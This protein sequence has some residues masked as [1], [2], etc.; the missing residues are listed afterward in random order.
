M[1]ALNDI[2]TLDF[3]TNANTGA[4]VDAD[5][6]PTYEIFEDDNDTPILSGNATKRTSKTGNYRITF[7]ASAAN[8]FENGK[9]YN[10]IA[11]AT[12]ATIAGK[13]R[14]STFKV[15]TSTLSGPSS[16][17][18]TFEDSNSDPVPL[19]N[20]TILGIA[21]G[22]ADVDGEAAFGLLD[23][24]YTVVAAPTQGVFFPNTTLVVS[25][26][27]TQTITGTSPTVTPPANPDLSLVYG[28]LVD[29]SG[30]PLA[31]VKVKFTLVSTG[32]A[33]DGGLL[34]Q[35]NPPMEA[36]TDSAGHFEIEL[37]KTSALLPS[38][39]LYRIECAPAKFN[40]VTA[41]TA[42]S[43]DITSLIT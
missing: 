4:A 30:N 36:T 9:Y 23:G 19:V 13:A 28:D 29:L 32:A 39:C 34:Q 35:Q 33:V 40:Q 42:A 31:G 27:T 1:A 5:S 10:V 22:Q 11:L 3:I 2:V 8:G 24:T 26:T 6:T 37:T 12:V 15:E 38:G 17:T 41:I 21:S 14:V 16:V 43:F 18:L 25:G 20:F 7:T